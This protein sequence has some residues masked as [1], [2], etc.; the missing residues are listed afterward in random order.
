MPV[1]SPGF[2]MKTRLFDLRIWN[3]VVCYF[4]LRIYRGDPNPELLYFCLATTVVFNAIPFA[5]SMFK[6]TRDIFISSSID[7]LWFTGIGVLLTSAAIY[8][9]LEYTSKGSFS[10]ASHFYPLMQACML[11]GTASLVFLLV[12][13]VAP[14]RTSSKFP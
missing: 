3:L 7:I 14:S 6:S 12:R 2:N 11:Q 4:P 9:N 13:W 1:V 8:L 5:W 10:D